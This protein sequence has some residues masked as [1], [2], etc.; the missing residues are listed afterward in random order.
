[1]DNDRYKPLEIEAKWRKIWQ[2]KKIYEVD[3]EQ[4]LAVD[5]AKF[6]AFA[7]FNYPSG[8]GTH[9]G[10]VKNFLL[11]DILLR[12]RRQ[13][14]DLVY[15]PV[16]FDAF[17]L[18][19]E[20]FAI[21][22][23]ISPQLAIEKAIANYI[24]QYKICGFSFDWSKIINTSQANYY[25][26]TQ[27]CFLQLYKSGMAYQKDSAQWW[28]E[29][30][31]TVLADEQ[32][33]NGKCWRHDGSS[34]SPVGR[35]NLEQWFF[36]ITDYAEEILQAAS[37]LHWTEWVKTAQENYIGR[38]EGVEIVFSLKGLNLEKKTLKV[39][40]TALETIYGATFMV[41]AP[42]H[43]LVAEILKV[44]RNKEELEEYIRSAQI[45]SE[46]A[47]QQ[48]KTKTGVKVDG[49]KTVNPLTKMEMTVWLADYVLA[50]YGTGAMMAVPG[51]DERD[52]E[53]AKK[54]G[55]AI[56]YP[57]QANDFV[58]Y[59]TIS[60]A[61]SQH[62]LSTADDLNG[63]DMHSAK[64]VI[65]KKLKSL[66][67]ADKKVNY[68]LRDWLI[69]RQ[70]YWGTPIPIVYCPDCG[71]VPV[72]EKDLPVELPVVN[73]YKP[74]GD[75]RSPLTRVE[76]WVRV[77][78]PDCGKPA[79]RE[80]D[81]MDTFVC[82]S[83]YQMRYLS[84]NDDE[85]AW[86]PQIAEK[87]FPVDFYN[88]GDH[89]TAHLLYARF[90]TRFFYKKGLLPTPE[91]FTNMYFHA[92]IQA[93]DG[94][95]MS[96]SKGTGVDPIDII[97]QGYGADALRV[98]I[99]SIAPPDVGVAWNPNGVPGAYRFLSRI[100]VLVGNYLRKKPVKAN[101]QTNEDLELLRATHRCILKNNRDIERL[102]YNTALS[103]Q[104][105]LVNTFYKSADIDNF[106][107]PAWQFC[108]E[109]LAMLL[110]PFA[111]HLASE[112]WQQLGHL[113]SV[114]LNH[115]P[116]VN[117]D[118]LVT[119]KIIIPIQ[120]NGKLRGRIEIDADASKEEV[121]KAARKVE[122]VSKYLNQALVKEEKYVPKRIIN[123]VL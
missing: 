117:Q 48:A 24:E 106:Q 52:L 63:L 49:L 98:C 3:L 10:H 105:E 2:E 76:A 89:A 102:K 116:R 73:D 78:C 72:K 26:W 100:W 96:K 15:S 111:P 66:K 99:C 74:A 27:W 103:A 71:V 9:L 121:L 70:R 44:A 107:N 113:D 110:A 109:T 79:E 35:K 4:D 7:M 91:P 21:K 123:F 118:Y 65:F 57:T 114:N 18:P 62:Y 43:P 87:W 33:S 14:G 115:W 120:V 95:V 25:R 42:E 11:A 58:A 16:G 60:Q 34:D 5:Q 108:L 50:D 13:K 83:W 23:G 19:A 40:T 36:K 8:E 64:T 6:Y 101:T 56:I 82:S 69:S 90:F 59:K 46:L 47:R 119:E 85:Q 31:K 38:S 75:G 1:M 17:G 92:K 55:L 88:G 22:T 54:S 45:K 97:K 61:P 80:T 51:A 94:Q 29:A 77:A 67:I 30:C 86:D 53:F 12:F 93:V 32:V 68:K 41:L 81:T 28:C 112:L 39:F 104:M 122:T 37:K 84:A 20:N